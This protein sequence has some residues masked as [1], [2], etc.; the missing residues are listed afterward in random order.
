MTQPNQPIHEIVRK[1]N[2][3]ESVEYCNSHRLQLP[4][5]SSVDEVEGNFYLGVTK[6]DRK[7]RNYYTGEIMETLNLKLPESSE[8]YVTNIGTVDSN[9][10]E[11]YQQ[12][13]RVVCIQSKPIDQILG[14]SKSVLIWLEEFCSK[15]I[16]FPSESTFHK[17]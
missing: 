3:T 2:F 8:T 9:S 15:R 10:I 13:D 14:K 17:S 12:P 6:Q 5:I 1:I 16:Y 4:T 11:G 7:Y